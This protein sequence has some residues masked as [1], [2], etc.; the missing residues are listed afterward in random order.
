[1][2]REES[3]EETLARLGVRVLPPPPNGAHYGKVNRRNGGSHPQ[4]TTTF[5]SPS[6]QPNVELVLAEA[7]EPAPIDWLWDGWLAKGKLQVLAGQPGTGKTTLAIALAAITS[8]GGVWPDGSQA[9]AGNVVIWS[10]EDDPAD[11]LVPRLIAAGAGR[12]RIYF[13]KGV[14]EDGGKR[15]FDPAKDMGP[16]SQAMERIGDV[17]LVIIDPIAMVAVKDS[18]RNA[19]TR[20]DLQPVADLCQAT[21]AAGL[22]IH[23]L[24][25]GTVGRE[26]HERLIGSIAFA[27]VAR[28]VMIATKTP[29]REGERNERRVL[30]RAKSNIGPDEGGYVYNLEQ[31]ELSEY[32]IFASRVLWGEAVDGTARE[33]LAEAESDGERSPR[34]DAKGFLRSFL[35]EGPAAAKE[36]Q[37][38][39]R[40][41][42]IS[43]RTLERAK[44]ELRIRT[45]RVGFGKDSV[46]QWELSENN[47]ID[48]HAHHRSPLSGL[49]VYGDGGGQWS[50]EAGNAENREGG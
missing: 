10:G 30:I 33:V 15:S 26:P 41:E 12:S 29:P 43:L 44:A 40:G 24:A 35:S 45:F 14:S 50:G 48:R 34:E 4:P 49:A 1:M 37:A 25:K 13:V 16:L 20:R 31:I 46:F 42:G 18:H 32:S 38:A 21:A 28:V 39:A 19:E 8:I 7:I 5:A 17:K 11:T 9:T 23:H 3:P 22:G 6:K 36:V 47:T 2:K 27:A